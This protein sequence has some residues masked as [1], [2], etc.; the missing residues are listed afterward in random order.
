MIFTYLSATGME[1]SAFQFFHESELAHTNI[2]TKSLSSDRFVEIL[3]K[4]VTMD[5]IENHM[6]PA[7]SIIECDA[8]NT[9]ALPHTCYL[10][11]DG[12]KVPVVIPES[13][14]TVALNNLRASPIAQAIM[15][16][17]EPQPVA[18][19]VQDQQRRRFYNISRVIQLSVHEKDITTV[20]WNPTTPY[21]LA[22]G[23][24]DGTVCIW[25]LQACFNQMN[26]YGGCVDGVYD[27]IQPPAGVDLSNRVGYIFLTESRK[28][29]E[30]QHGV[31]VIRWNSTGS[32]LFVGTGKQKVYVWTSEGTFLG[33]YEHHDGPIVSLQVSPDDSFLLTTSTDNKC[34]IWD[35]KIF[36]NQHSPFVCTEP[37]SVHSTHTAPLLGGEWRD[38]LCFVTYASNGMVCLNIVGLNRPIAYFTGHQ[39]EVNR[40][41]WSKDRTRL[42]SCSDDKLAIVWDVHIPF[43]HDISVWKERGRFYE[44]QS[45]QTIASKKELKHLNGVYDLVWDETNGKNNL[46]TSCFDYH[47]YTWNAENG[48]IVKRH[49]GHRDTVYA[50]ALSPD[51]KYLATGANDQSLHLWNMATDSV[52]F[53]A[54]KSGELTTP[55]ST[56]TLRF[57]SLFLCLVYLTVSIVGIV[58]LVKM[59]RFRIVFLS[60][61]VFG[62]IGVCVAYVGFWKKGFPTKKGEKLTPWISLFFMGNL[63]LH[64]SFI[65]IAAASYGL[66]P[67]LSFALTI[68]EE[69]IK[70]LFPSLS[71]KSMEDLPK[72]VASLEAVLNV[73]GVFTTLAAVL[74]LISIILVSIHLGAHQFVRFFLTFGSIIMMI[75]GAATAF[76]LLFLNPWNIKMGDALIIPEAHYR[77]L[78]LLSFA[79][80]AV[81]FCGLFSVYLNTRCKW[82]A[83][84]YLVGSI[85]LYLFYL[86]FAI[87][88]VRLQYNLGKTV[89]A[90][91]TPDP[92]GKK[93]SG[94]CEL[95]LTIYQGR[96]CPQTD[97]T[98]KT[99][100][101]SK[102]S[103]QALTDIYVNL[104][105][106][107]CSLIL[108][109]T[110]YVIIFLGIYDIS[111]TLNL[112]ERKPQL[113]EGFRKLTQHDEEFDGDT[114]MV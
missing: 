67:S 11:R 24:A 99:E 73:V 109:I 62:I 6:T 50:L 79:L 69:K 89:P 103:K 47:L 44:E 81:G 53:T 13:N 94:K 22:S 29:P 55:R 111:F 25:N 85:V 104:A 33:T 101:E 2:D 58:G 66:R 74:Q 76:F 83:G 40:V 107:W 56:Q 37:F 68:P 28:A 108:W 51:G 20:Q 52:V 38:S 63:L 112:F 75:M 84:V 32:I 61:I 114:S 36:V 5:S 12:R 35:A 59:P 64:A 78:I 46:I 23:S 34:L 113:K 92:D 17:S 30:D 41:A 21:I 49:P 48:E 95:L 8:P 90:L 45:P 72:L 82:L 60:T 27:M 102:I 88:T 57:F 96:M 97:Q 4:G 98:Q 100:C 91:C 77:T 31:T 14:M 43:E 93:P 39:G 106:G 16:N 9:L 87:S 10:K 70:E 86:V 80:C 19:H 65:F 54:L 110:V 15:R 105:S 26:G 42:A 7:G 18:Q 71:V 1:H 3:L